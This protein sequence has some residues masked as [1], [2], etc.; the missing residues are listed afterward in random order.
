MAD[1]SNVPISPVVESAGT[2]YVSG[3][4]STDHLHE[5]NHLDVSEQTTKVLERIDSILVGVGSSKA[6]IVKTTVFLTDV[7]RDFDAMN[8]AYAAFF[9]SRFPARTTIGV[10]LAVAVLVEIEAIAVRGAS[11]RQ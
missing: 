3:Q 9:E 11:F 2:L 8:R 1:L 4:I 5:P 10:D 6:D 7:K